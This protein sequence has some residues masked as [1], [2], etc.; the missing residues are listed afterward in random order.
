[1]VGFVSREAAAA[2][3]QL[4]DFLCTFTAAR[5]TNSL[6]SKLSFEDNMVKGSKNLFSSNDNN[7][8]NSL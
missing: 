5:I 7:E 1:M 8:Y 4:L 3:F 6:K 2:I